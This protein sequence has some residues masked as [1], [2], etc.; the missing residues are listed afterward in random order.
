MGY[1]LFCDEG[2]LG[3]TL[4]VGDVF[5]EAGPLAELR[6]TFD[7]IQAGLFFHLWDRDGQKRAAKNIVRLLK[8]EVGILLVGQQVGSSKPG[9]YP[10]A[11]GTM[12]RHDVGSWERF[13]EEVGEETGSKWVVRAVLDDG[14]GMEARKAWDDGGTRR[15]GFEVERVE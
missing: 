10:S 11:R 1:R 5:D 4:L 7:I 13:W 6:G 12:F 8:P 14:L 9:E 3:A 15:L 2:R